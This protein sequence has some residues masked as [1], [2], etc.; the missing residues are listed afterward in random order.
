[1]K[2]TRAYQHKNSVT[3]KTSESTKT[4]IS[5]ECELKMSIAAKYFEVD[6]NRFPE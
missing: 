4:L 6:R 3:C 5:R 1:M 2:L